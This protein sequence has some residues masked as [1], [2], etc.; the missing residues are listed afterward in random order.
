[1]NIIQLSLVFER[2]FGVFN[3]TYYLEDLKPTRI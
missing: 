3:K 1:M 2:N